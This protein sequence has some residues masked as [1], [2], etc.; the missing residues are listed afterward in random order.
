MT[1]LR[2]WVPLRETSD[3]LVHSYLQTFES[4]YRILHIPTFQHEYNQYWINPQSANEVFVIKLLL[5]MAIGTSFYEDSDTLTSLRLSSSQWIYAAQS[6]LVSPSEKS[7]LN[8]S[9]LQIHCLLLLARQ[10]N[11]IAGDLIWISAGSLIRTAVQ[12]GLHRDPR[13]LPR[14]PIFHA[15]IRRRLWATVLEI[16]VQ[17]SMDSGGPPLI[18]CEDFDCES[19]SNINDGQIDE[20][21]KLPPVSKSLDTMTQTSV[22]IALMRT[23]PIR[24]EVTKLI[25][26]FRSDPSYDDVLCLGAELTSAYRANSL[27]SD[28]LRTNEAQPSAFQTKLL[29]LLTHRF[30]L[31][32]HQP[33]ALKARTNLSYYYS[34]KICLES[35]LLLLSDSPSP[36]NLDSHLQNDHFT[37]LKRVGGGPFR[38]VLLHAAANIGLELITQLQEQSSSFMSESNIVQRKE[39]HKAIEGYIELTICRIKAGETNVKGHIFFSCVMAQINAMHAGT[40][41]EESILEALNRSTETSYQL[42]KAKTEDSAAQRIDENAETQQD[43]G[44]EVLQN[45]FEWSDLVC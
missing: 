32:L 15:E 39:L 41:L 12:M 9:G 31:A 8:L 25:N 24:L 13:H 42:L 16:V 1:D 33:F 30:L 10:T 18:S 43:I 19:P 6:W 44:F 23:L 14:M 27:S 11:A 26:D 2:S 35:S 3:Q 36:Q 7:R 29:G 45:G 21:T 38:G 34:R 17:S 37:R 4:V 40:S 5:V 28:S 22:Q 20:S